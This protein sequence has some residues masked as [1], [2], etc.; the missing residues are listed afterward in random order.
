MVG[1]VLVSASSCQNRSPLAEHF[2]GGNIFLRCF[3]ETLEPP[4]R[5]ELLRV[6][7]IRPMMVFSQVVINKTKVA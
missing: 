4:Y 7:M 3:F 6:T 2:L 1:N 5:G